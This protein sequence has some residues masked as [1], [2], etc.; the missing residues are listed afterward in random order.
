MEDCFSTRGFCRF[1]PNRALVPRRFPRPHKTD[2]N[3]A[4]PCPRRDGGRLRLRRRRRRGRGRRPAGVRRVRPVVPP[5][6][7][8]L[9]RPGLRRVVVLQPAGQPVLRGGDERLRVP[10]VARVLHVARRA[11]QVVLRAGELH[12]RRHLRDAQPAESGPDAGDADP[13]ADASAG[14][15]TDPQAHGGA[16]RVPR[17][18]LRAALLQPAHAVLFVFG[19][20]NG[21]LLG[22]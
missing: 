2:S 9:R 3:A 13:A 21:L 6:L 1:S 22:Q 10:G 20:H 17:D 16:V 14:A 18:A 8:V 4:T 19:R 11:A 15:D 7:G 12:G 5:R